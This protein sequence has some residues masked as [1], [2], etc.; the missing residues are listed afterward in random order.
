MLADNLPSVVFRRSVRGIR[1]VGPTRFPRCQEALIVIDVG[2]P[3][4]KNW[5][6]SGPK[7]YW[8]EL[9]PSFPLARG[10]EVLHSSS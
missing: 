10:D 1:A 5:C 9:D 8:W 2:E 4:M 6:F 3:P 7:E